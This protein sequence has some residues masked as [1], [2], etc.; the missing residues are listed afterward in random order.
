MIVSLIDHVKFTSKLF[1]IFFVATDIRLSLTLWTFV[2]S[3]AKPMKQIILFLTIV[4][5]TLTAKAQP[6]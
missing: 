2:S 5:I 3:N 6:S 4:V 1:F